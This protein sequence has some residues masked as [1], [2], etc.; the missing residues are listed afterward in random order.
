MVSSSTQNGCSSSSSSSTNRQ[1]GNSPIRQVEKTSIK[2][3]I[4][5]HGS[6]FVRDSLTS[7]EISDKSKEIVM[8]VQKFCTKPTRYTYIWDINKVLTYI[9]NMPDNPRGVL[10]IFVYGGVRMEGKI[11][12]QKYGFPENLAPKNIRILHMTRF[13]LQFWC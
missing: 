10:A 6:S 12:T 1:S 5:T 8:S 9:V 11:Q 4:E 2:K 7:K 3:Q 13:L